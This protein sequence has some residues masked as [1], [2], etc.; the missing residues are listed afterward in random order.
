MMR[1]E[2][3]TLAPSGTG[4]LSITFD[5][6]NYGG[7]KVTKQVFITSNDTTNA[8]LTISFNVNVVNVVDVKPNIVSF[9]DSKMDSTYTK[10]VTISNHAKESLKIVSVSTTL[11][12]LKVDIIK[13]QLMP[14]ES[15]QLQAVLHPTM[16]GTFSGDINI[17]TDNKIQPKIQLKVY[18]WVTRK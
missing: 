8:R 1:Q 13:R 3:M 10:T 15:T 7:S 5:T 11:E 14:G 17:E 12:P 16:S 18:A 6:L 4:R 9:N 2:E